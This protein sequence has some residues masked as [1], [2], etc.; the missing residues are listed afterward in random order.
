MSVMK[1]LIR[2]WP[3]LAL[4][5]C[6]QP[7]SNPENLSKTEELEK[8]PQLEFD[9]Q[10]HRGARGLFPENSIEGFIA[11]VELQVNTLEM[12][13]VITKD[14]QVIVS[15]EP[16]IS[17]VICWGFDDRPVA[18]GKGLNIYNMTY[19]EVTNY[20]CGSQPHPDFPLQA[21]LST[22]KPLLSEVVTEVESNV[23][24]LDLEPVF[25]N[26][27]IKSTPDGD[28]IFHPVPEE[29]CKLVLDQI[30]ASGIH[31][32][33]II[34]SF[35]VRS[36]NAMKRLDPSV[37]VALLIAQSQGF[38]RDL[39]EL[40]FTPDI[41]SPNFR[42]VDEKLVNSCHQNGIKLIP[43][44]VNEEEDMVRLLELG[45]DGL[46]TDFPDVALTLKM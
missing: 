18:E 9:L 39:E 36:L 31:D 27:E 6:T 12:D 29:F 34:Q 40:G 30:N 24:S 4:V 16:W 13:V 11:A 25:Y 20:N 8:S 35:D 23:A 21:K 46:I 45:V 17:S 14:K 37:P 42:L 44:T 10:G 41:Y 26:I 38:E 3:L 32:R 43:W 22:F 28:E 7:D 5:A 1:R 19:A 15:H 33:A 2:V